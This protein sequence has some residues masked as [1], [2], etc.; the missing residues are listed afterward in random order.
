MTVR[1]GGAPLEPGRKIYYSIT[2]VAE[3]ADV[4]PHVL[5]YWET[6]FTA[7]RPKK[8]RAG[9]RIYRERDVKLVLLIRRLLYEEGFTIKGA[10]KRLQEKRAEQL[11]QIEIPFTQQEKDR[12]MTRLREELESILAELG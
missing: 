3:M 1:S 10:R 5:R 4:K 8:N 11:D 12:T 7:L 2:E 6:E 9:N